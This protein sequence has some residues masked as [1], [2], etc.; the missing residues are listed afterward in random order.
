MAKLIIEAVIAIAIVGVI[1]Y[2][3]VKKFGNK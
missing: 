3:G 1:V 2:F